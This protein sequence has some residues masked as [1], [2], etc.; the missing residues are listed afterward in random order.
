VRRRV[1]DRSSGNCARQ[2]F[3]VEASAIAIPYDVTSL[4]LLL[5]DTADKGCSKIAINNAGCSH[6]QHHDKTVKEG[7]TMAMNGNKRLQLPCHCRLVTHCSMRSRCPGDD[8]G[9]RTSEFPVISNSKVHVSRP[10]AAKIGSSSREVG[11]NT[12]K[13]EALPCPS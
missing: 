3:A 2:N 9:R 12:I 11:G 5:V 1:R 4:E 6:Q 10:D 8:P 13:R 7:R